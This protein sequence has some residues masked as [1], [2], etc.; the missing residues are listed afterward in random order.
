MPGRSVYALARCESDSFLSDISVSDRSVSMSERCESDSCVSDEFV[1][2]RS[3]FN[4]QD[5]GKC[6]CVFVCVCV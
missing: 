5:S 3:I 2:D 1:Y 4:G 6:K